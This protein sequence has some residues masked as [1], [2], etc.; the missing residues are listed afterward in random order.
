MKILYEAIDGKIFT[1]E[2]ECYEYET[3]LK[4]PELLTIDFFDEFDNIYHIKAEDIFNE[5]VY[6]LC[7]KVYIRTEAELAAFKFLT[8]ETGWCEFEDI[9]STGVWRRVTN[10][11][12]NGY[13]KKC[14][15]F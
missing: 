3:L 10:S 12:N 13:Y 4:Y 8:S 5:I 2:D 6:N 9:D 1:N 11:W 7:E 14:D 15:V